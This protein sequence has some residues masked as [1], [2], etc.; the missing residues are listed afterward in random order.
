MPEP[1]LEN[2]IENLF[3]QLR[4]HLKLLQNYLVTTK[5]GQL[6]LIMNKDTEQVFLNLV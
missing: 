3:L 5:A 2:K 1:I 6:Q 4:M